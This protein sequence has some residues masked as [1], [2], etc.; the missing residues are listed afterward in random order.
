MTD[1]PIFIVGC[2]RSGT[3]LWRDLLRSHPRLTFP[4]EFHFIPEL[5]RVYGD[6]SRE[7]HYEDLV[8]EP[9]ARLQELTS[10][11]GLR[12]EPKMLEYHRELNARRSLNHKRLTKPASPGGSDWRKQMRR[13]DIERFEALAGDLLETLG[14]NVHFQVL[15]PARGS[16]RCWIRRAPVFA[17][18]W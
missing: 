3:T 14:T 15:R 18:P 5:Y 10:F 4:A 1:S 6:P 13:A 16:E 9:E 2:P 17:C 12:F 8:S 11:L 7:L